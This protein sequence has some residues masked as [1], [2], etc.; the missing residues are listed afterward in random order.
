MFNAEREGIEPSL[1]RH[2]RRRSSRNHFH[3]A[4]KTNNN[5][6][7][8]LHPDETPW[9]SF[10]M[11][12]KKC[13]D[14]SYLNSRDKLDAVPSGEILFVGCAACQF[15][16]MECKAVGFASEIVVQSDEAPYAVACLFRQY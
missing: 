6:V 3:F 11:I 5:N 7:R 16:V 15:V 10:L 14:E 4:I 12:N 13:I 9:V 2:P 8:G 1:K